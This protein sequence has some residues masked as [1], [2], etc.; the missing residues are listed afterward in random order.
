MANGFCLDYIA[1]RRIAAER[2]ELRHLGNSSA[3]TLSNS[4]YSARLFSNT[5]PTIAVARI[6]EDVPSGTEKAVRVFSRP[7]SCDRD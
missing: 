7:L 6:L 3:A 5:A 4:A 1:S 2:C